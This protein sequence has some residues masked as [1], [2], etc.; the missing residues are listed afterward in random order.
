VFLIAN[1]GGNTNVWHWQDNGALDGNVQNTE[2]TK[3]GV[4]EG[5]TQSDIDTMTNSNII[6]TQ[7]VV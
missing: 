2:L 6:N 4:L 3:L 5:V 7:F 1:S